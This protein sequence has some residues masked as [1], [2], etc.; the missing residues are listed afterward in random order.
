MKNTQ[1]N[2]VK[3]SE[4]AECRFDHRKVCAT[5]EWGGVPVI[6]KSYVSARKYT[7]GVQFWLPAQIEAGV[8]KSETGDVSYFVEKLYADDD[9]KGFWAAAKNLEGELVWE[10]MHLHNFM[11]LDSSLEILAGKIANVTI[12]VAIKKAMARRAGAD[13][14]DIARIQQQYDAAQKLLPAAR[15]TAWMA[16]KQF[17]PPRIQKCMM[18]AI[19]EE[20][21]GL[22][23]AEAVK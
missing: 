17:L 5:T 21:I 20:H 4:I 16:V 6:V 19:H 18:V 11:C 2:T 22:T 9:T 10:Y 14:V 12:N 23:P 1:N 15:Q 8:Y 13:E 7:V 3:N